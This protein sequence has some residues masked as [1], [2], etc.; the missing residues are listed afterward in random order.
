M[1]V[2]G[3]YF[4][5]RF[6]L[7][8]SALLTNRSMMTRSKSSTQPFETRVEHRDHHFER[9]ASQWND[10]Y[11]NVLKP[12]VLTP[13]SSVANEMHDLREWPLNGSAILGVR[14]NSWCHRIQSWSPLRCSLQEFCLSMD[15]LLRR[16]TGADGTITKEISLPLRYP[17]GTR[18]SGV[19]DG[20]TSTTAS[21]FTPLPS[22][23]VHI[24]PKS[25]IF[26]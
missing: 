21:S 22:I 15:R 4:Y 12:M 9:A 16:C 7:I 25:I 18:T 6:W 1:S 19:W 10:G 20:S 24:R 5:F 17:H 26:F 2:S 14:W 8:W 23:Y 13:V 3:F 11:H